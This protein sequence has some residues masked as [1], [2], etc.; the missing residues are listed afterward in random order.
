MEEAAPQTTPQTPAPE[1]QEGDQT[2]V[3]TPST[4]DNT[5]TPSPETEFPEQGKTTDPEIEK[6]SADPL[7]GVEGDKEIADGMPEEPDTTVKTFQFT[8]KIDGEEE[9]VELTQDDVKRNYQKMMAAD[10]R[11]EEAAQGRKQ[12]FEAIDRMKDPNQLPQVLEAMGYDVRQ[13]AEQFLYQQL[14][15]EALTPEQ[16]RGLEMQRELQRRDAIDQQR[17][18]QYDAQEKSVQSQAMVQEIQGQIIDALKT[19]NLP[20]T[21]D[22]VKR[23]A[24]EMSRN[25][26]RGI[27]ITAAEAAKYVER[28]LR[29]QIKDL[30]GKLPPEKLD[31]ILGP[32]V[33]KKL[34]QRDLA[35]IKNPIQTKGMPPVQ[36]K[37][38]L[39]QKGYLDEKDFEKHLARM[40]ST[41][42]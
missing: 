40:K 33:G 14:Q 41:K 39:P 32:D 10:K 1:A 7:E 26:K 34:R 24:N 23:M 28:D 5:G 35:K 16:R 12:V 17:Q 30:T 25:V 4:L 13:L 9:E 6:L 3:D 27:S 21:A 20:Q 29:R 19:S 8:C 31:D 15:Y 11:F 22:S 18:Q 38:K 37:E 42:K 2:T 36:Q